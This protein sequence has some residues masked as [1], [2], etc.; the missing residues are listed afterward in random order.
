M[1]ISS[2]DLF[3][4]ILVMDSYNRGCS[5]DLKISNSDLIGDAE[6]GVAKGHA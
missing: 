6:I 4:A 2:A 1:T 3:R 5:A